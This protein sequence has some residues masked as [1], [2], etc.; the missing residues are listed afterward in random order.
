L[1]SQALK[2]PG[3]RRAT[4]S[5][6]FVKVTLSA[7]PAFA[8]L[9]ASLPRGPEMINDRGRFSGHGRNSVAAGGPAFCNEKLFAIMLPG[10]AA[11][12]GAVRHMAHVSA[13]RH[14]TLPYRGWPI[15]LPGANK[16]RQ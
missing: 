9:T 16:G 14:M 7:R 12:E 10:G 1:I 3:N 6:H 15:R 8:G 2:L 5:R 4:A 13:V 11:R